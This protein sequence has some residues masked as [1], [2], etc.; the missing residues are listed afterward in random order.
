MENDI[1]TDVTVREAISALQGEMLGYYK[2]TVRGHYGLGIQGPDFK[3]VGLGE[4]SHITHIEV[5]GPVGSEIE[6]FFKGKSDLIKQGEKIGDK[7]SKQ[8]IKWSNSTFVENL[9]H[10]N[11]SETFPQSPAN[12]LGVVD[13]FDVPESEKSIVQESILNNS[14]NTS[15][16]LFFNDETNI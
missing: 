3:V 5:K 13:S 11:R 15:S 6:K 8:Q 9:N 16:V 7:I 2:D 4:Y 1:T 12:V 10:V 14:T